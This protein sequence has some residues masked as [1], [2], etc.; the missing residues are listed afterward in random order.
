MQ[1]KPGFYITDDGKLAYIERLNH[2]NFWVGYVV[3]KLTGRHISATWYLG[4]NFSVHGPMPD[5]LVR[6]T[7]PEEIERMK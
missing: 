3:S 6:H 4:G 2:R 1:I 7:T 5:D